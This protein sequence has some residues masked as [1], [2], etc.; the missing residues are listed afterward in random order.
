[1]LWLHGYWLTLIIGQTM[2]RRGRRRSQ[3]GVNIHELQDGILGTFVYLRQE[4]VPAICEV[5]GEQRDPPEYEKNRQ[6]KTKA[7]FLQPMLH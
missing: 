4:P 5:V 7:D 1:M 6:R 3:G 2:S